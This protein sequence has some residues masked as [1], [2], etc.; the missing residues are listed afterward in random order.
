L[1]ELP[2]STLKRIEDLLCRDCHAR[3]EFL[4]ALFQQR[5]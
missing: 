3:I 5:A 1:I 4:L 2:G